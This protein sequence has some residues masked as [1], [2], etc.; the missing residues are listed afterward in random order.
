ME[1]MPGNAKIKKI[2]KTFKLFFSLPGKVD[3]DV[4]R[5]ANLGDW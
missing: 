2:I 4:A 3:M 5:S 1:M